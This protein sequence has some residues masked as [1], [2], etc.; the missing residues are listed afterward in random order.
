M[1]S[2]YDEYHW[3]PRKKKMSDRIKR[4][5]YGSGFS[6]NVSRMEEFEFV[7]VISPSVCVCVCDMK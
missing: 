7:C 6:E 2:S 3:N 4:T 5:G 1:A